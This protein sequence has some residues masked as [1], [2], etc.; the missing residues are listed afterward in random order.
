[1]A[2]VKKVVKLK[3]VAKNWLGWYRLMAK[4]LITKIQVNFVLSWDEATQ[5]DLNCYQIFCHKPIHVP[6][7]PILGRSHSHTGHFEQGC[8]FFTARLFCVD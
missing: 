6:S 8:T 2:S 4:N 3:G 1:M 7:Q 5:I